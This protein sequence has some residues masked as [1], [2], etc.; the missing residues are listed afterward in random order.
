M[1]LLDH[2]QIIQDIADRVSAVAD[3][4]WSEILIDYHIEGVQSDLALSCLTERDGATV[5][6]SLLLKRELRLHELD[7]CLRQLQKCLAQGRQQPFTSCK[8]RF[9]SSGKF[10]A[11][12]GYDPI[13]WSALLRSRSAVRS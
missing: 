13:D 10:D 5:R 7:A 4:D 8:L 1:L 2:T 9:S 6:T 12:Y 3:T 11:T